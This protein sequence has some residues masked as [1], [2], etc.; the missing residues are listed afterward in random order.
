MRG[1]RHRTIRC[2]LAGICL[3]CCTS[4]ITGCIPH[5]SEEYTLA[6]Q[7]TNDTWYTGKTPTTTGTVEPNPSTGAGSY[8]SIDEKNGVTYP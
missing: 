4:L 5:S 6:N 8:R 2:A 1:F 7:T 3:L